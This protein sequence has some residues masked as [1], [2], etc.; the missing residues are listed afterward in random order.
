MKKGDVITKDTVICIIEAMKVMNEVK[1]GV[2]GVV[3]EVLIE[4][5]Q[6]VEFGTKLFKIS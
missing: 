6:P 1:A 3:A 5:G 4:N 2:D